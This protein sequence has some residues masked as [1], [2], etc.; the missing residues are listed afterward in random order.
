M[1]YVEPAEEQ[2][3]LEGRYGEMSDEQIA[4]MW[5]QI[6]DLTD[7]AQQVLRAE[8]S[9]RGMAK[10]SQVFSDDPVE[11]ARQALRVTRAARGLSA[12]ARTA[13]G[14][15]P[16]ATCS[17]QNPSDPATGD[18]LPQGFDPDAF[19][20]VSVWDV[21]SPSEARE[22][23]HIL[24]T[25]GVKCYLGPDNVENIDDYKGS[26]DDEVEI[27][28]MKFQRGFVINGLR[29]YLQPKPEDAFL[30]EGAYDVRCPRCGS[31][32]VILEGLDPEL[33]RESAPEVKNKWRCPDCDHRWEDDGIL[34]RG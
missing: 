7:L 31:Q 15:L 26:W 14:Q 20:L 13:T 17:A 16:E 4:L 21:S 34:K 8:I 1:D 33:R 11:I 5:T 32:D 18:A 24:E 19:D 30:E 22:V 12:E 25:V 6:D 29:N 3:K 23:A 27:K 28:V 10:Q 9:K 2:R